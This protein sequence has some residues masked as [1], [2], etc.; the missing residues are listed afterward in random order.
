M[1]AAG[2]AASPG[3]AG[4]AASAVVDTLDSVVEAFIDAN[5]QVNTHLTGASTSQS[6]RVRANHAFSDLGV[7]G[8]F[9][10]S[11]SVGV[12]AAADVEVLQ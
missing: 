5:A 3:D 2:F 7:A 1:F 4:I 10:G 12:G 6:V 11:T 8:S 9:G